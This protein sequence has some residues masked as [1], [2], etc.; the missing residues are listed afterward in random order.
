MSSVEHL[1]NSQNCLK[2][3]VDPDAALNS[4]DTNPE[5]FVS[6]ALDLFYIITSNSR[7]WFGRSVKNPDSLLKRGA[8]TPCWTNGNLLS[9]HSEQNLANF[10]GFWSSKL[11]LRVVDSLYIYIYIYTHTH[12]HKFCIFSGQIVL[13][14]LT[15]STFIT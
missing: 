12:I 2:G 13:L 3:S 10:R 1:V 5:Q 14:R 4:A 7:L 8:K 11:L 15:S 6:V 9:R